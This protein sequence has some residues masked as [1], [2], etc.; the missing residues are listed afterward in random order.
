[1]D[2][3]LRLVICEARESAIQVM[4]ATS[5]TYSIQRLANLL[6]KETRLSLARLATKLIDR[7]DK[8][9]L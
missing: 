8:L 9:V 3:A 1:M 4:A 5:G 7:H 6:H 2:G